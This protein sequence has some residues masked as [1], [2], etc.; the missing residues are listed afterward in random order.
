MK[1]DSM[2]LITTALVV[3]ASTNIQALTYIET[4][5]F[6][7]TNGFRSI[8]GPFELGENYIQGDINALA[9][10]SRLSSDYGDYWSV[11]IPSGQ[12]ITDINIVLTGVTG[13]MRAFSSDNII[14][15]VPTSAGAYAQANTDGTYELTTTDPFGSIFTKGD[16]P[17]NAGRYYFGTVVPGINASAY[18]YEWRVTVEKVSAVPIPAAIW[19]FSSG[20]LGIVGLSIRK[21]HQIF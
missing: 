20:L 13:N 3:C 8:I 7:N 11:V 10:S 4:T 14:G 2:N 1:M 6:G 16:F 21:K 9:G 18:S 17:F 15:L 12:Q 5:D 19:L